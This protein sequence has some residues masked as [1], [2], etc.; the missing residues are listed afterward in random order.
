MGSFLSLIVLFE[1]FDGLVFCFVV[2]VDGNEDSGL[3]G[4]WCGVVVGVGGFLMGVDGLEV[5]LKF[6]VCL[7]EDVG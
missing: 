4:C 2:E 3:C 1:V 6:V 7:F 5:C